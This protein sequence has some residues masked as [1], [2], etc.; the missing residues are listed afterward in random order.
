MLDLRFTAQSLWRMLSSRILH[1]IIQFTDMS[2]LNP[3]GGNLRDKQTACR[4]LLAY[5]LLA[6]FFSPEDG[7]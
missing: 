2:Y 5:G 6:L 7:G 3:Q 1:R 4:L